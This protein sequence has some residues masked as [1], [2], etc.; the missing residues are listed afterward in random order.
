MKVP[1]ALACLGLSACALGPVT[2]D[3]AGHKI[4]MDGDA[5][6]IHQLTA[7]TWTATSPA[8]TKPLPSGAASKAALLDA[9]EKKSGCKV[10][11]SDYSR[12]GMQLDAQVACASGLKN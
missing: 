4:S 11:D 2:G 3:A 1:A 9:I 5:Y 8:A 12:Q 7:S 6:L 10:T